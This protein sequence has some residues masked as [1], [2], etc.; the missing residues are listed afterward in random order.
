MAD[1]INGLSKYLS[2]VLNYINNN[3][4]TV[5][6]VK[7]TVPLFTPD[8]HEHHIHPQV[9][10]A[11]QVLPLEKKPKVLGVTLHTHFIC[12]QHCN[13][14][15]VK[16]EQRNNLLKALA[17][18]ACGCDKE[19]LLTTYQTIDRPIL[20]YCCPVWTPSLRDTKWSRQQRAHSKAL[21]IA[22]GCL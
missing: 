21:R 4:L 12:T 20:S 5:S 13:N 7:S 1:L 10:M 6:T 8:T 15:A 9:K 22:T 11:N 18:T 19:T 17:G 3:K 2:Q 14:I 16:V